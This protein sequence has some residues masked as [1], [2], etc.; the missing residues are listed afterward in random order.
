MLAAR[1]LAAAFQMAEPA[2]ATEAAPDVAAS[3]ITLVRGPRRV[4]AAD[5]IALIA[6]DGTVLLEVVRDRAA[7]RGRQ[8]PGDE[9]VTAAL[10]GE[11]AL[12]VEVFPGGGRRVVAVVPVRVGAVRAVRTRM[13]AVRQG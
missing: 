3:V 2:R 9:A 1:L 4:E 7:S 13:Q 10:G 6:R 12:G 8:W 5:S 11:T